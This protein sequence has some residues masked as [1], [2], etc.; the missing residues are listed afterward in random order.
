MVK[1]IGKPPINPIIFITGKLSGYICW[2]FIILYFFEIRLNSLSLFSSVKY[3]A[4]LL[5]SVG[6]FITIISFFNLGNSVSFG[7]PL[8]KTT[9]KMGGIYRL[10]RNPMYLS[11]YLFTLSSILLTLNIFIFILGTY[12]IIVYHFI[13]LSEEK[14]LKNRFGAAYSNYCKKVRRYL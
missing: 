9:L 14:F 4:F 8:E 6:I 5:L 13:I 12:S 1:I 7:I 10:S 11:F 2:L 3:F